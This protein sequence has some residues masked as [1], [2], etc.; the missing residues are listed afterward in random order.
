MLTVYTD[1]ACLNNPGPGGWGVLILG[2][3]ESPI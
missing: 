3:P 2:A 1:G